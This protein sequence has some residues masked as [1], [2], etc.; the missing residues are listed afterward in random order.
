MADATTSFADA[1]QKAAALEDRKGGLPLRTLEALR[2]SGLPEVLRDRELSGA[3]ASVRD[4]ARTDASIAAIVASHV[5]AGWILRRSLPARQ[6]TGKETLRSV[7]NAAGIAGIRVG[8]GWQLD[9][10]TVVEAG[11]LTAEQ[12]VV[13]FGD[14]VGGVF[15]AAIEVDVAGLSSEPLA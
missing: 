11:G 10:A 9:G 14:A 7:A 5:A 2:S 4:L 8:E 13:L 3:L 6:P 12:L 1:R 15:A